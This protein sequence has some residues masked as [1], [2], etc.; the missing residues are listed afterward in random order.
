MGTTA[1]SAHL[2]KAFLEDFRRRGNVSAACETVG[3]PRRTLYRWREGDAAFA[4]AFAEAEVEATECLEEEARRRAVEGVTNEK[5]IFHHGKL[6]GTHVET[7][8]SDTLLIFLLKARAPEKYRERVD[9][10]H[11]GSIGVEHGDS[12]SP[13]QREGIRRALAGIT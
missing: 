6:I 8:Y 10:K 11:G 12:L 9:V 13:E 5:G 3:V 7:N 1:Q 2:K 4:A